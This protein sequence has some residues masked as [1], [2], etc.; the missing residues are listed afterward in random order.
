MKKNIF[1][2]II[3]V[4][5][6]FTQCKKQ[7]AETNS[8]PAGQYQNKEIKTETEINREFA[9]TF[10]PGTGRYT[11]PA[12]F[13]VGNMPYVIDQG[14]TWSCGSHAASTLH[15]KWVHDTKGYVYN[16]YGAIMSAYYIYNHI[17]PIFWESWNIF[18]FLRD[19]GNVNQAWWPVN[20]PW[21]SS[22]YNSFSQYDW[23]APIYKVP[24]F[25]YIPLISGSRATNSAVLDL[26][27]IKYI[28]STFNRPIA[29]RVSL[30]PNGQINLDANATWSDY[31]FTKNI[32][33]IPY[34][35]W[36]TIY[37]YDGPSDCFLAQNSWGTGWA[38]SNAGRFKI[39][40]NTLRWAANDAVFLKYGQ[41]N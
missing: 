1:L 28:I 22:N 14:S 33:T 29:V 6:L 26:D 9:A 20:A 36:I 23:I 39:K 8:E 11:F 30:N 38:K 24:G 16:E 17:Q 37:G 25:Y 32:T 13:T 31:G 35:H 41:Y 21:G 7:V 5:F 4:A 2:P 40:T 19:R 18:G 3:C 10:L 27:H 15:S 34:Q 12:S